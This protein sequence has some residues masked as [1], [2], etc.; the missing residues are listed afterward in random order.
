MSYTPHLCTARSCSSVQIKTILILAKY[1]IFTL[2]IPGYRSFDLSLPDLETNYHYTTVSKSKPRLRKRYHNAGLE[3]IF[4][5]TGIGRCG[6]ISSQGKKLALR[7]THHLCISTSRLGSHNDHTHPRRAFLPP[8]ISPTTRSLPPSFTLVLLPPTLKALRNTHLRDLSRCQPLPRTQRPNR[9]I[10]APIQSHDALPPLPTLG[11][12]H[13]RRHRHRRQPFLKLPYR[14]HR[15][16][17]LPRPGRPASTRYP[18]PTRTLGCQRRQQSDSARAGKP[19]SRPARHHDALG[20][21]G[22]H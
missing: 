11:H 14:R 8:R 20:I 16:L 12:P 6:I 5:R 4:Q 15:R 10:R 13:R 9:I 21:F 7:H 3:E 18:R 2:N 1:S 17:R 22:S 19:G